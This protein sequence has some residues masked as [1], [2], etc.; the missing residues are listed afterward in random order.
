MQSTGAGLT[1]PTGPTG[2]TGVQ[3]TQGVTGAQGIQGLVGPTGPTG[4]KGATGPQGVAGPVDWQIACDYATTGALP[5]NTYNNGSSGVGATLTGIGLGALSVDGGSLSINQRI[6]VKNEATQANNGIYVVTVVGTVG[7]AYVLTRSTD[8]NQSSEMNVGDAV[9]ILNGVVNDD[10]TWVMVTEGTITVGTTAIVWVQASGIGPQGP[11]GAQGVQGIQGPI[12]PTG[13]TGATPSLPNFTDSRTFALMGTVTSASIPV[14]FEPVDSGVTKKLTNTRW[15][16]A[17][18]TA[19]VAVHQNG[20]NVSGLGAVLLS[21]ALGAT[22]PT[23][24]P[25]VTDGDRFGIVVSGVPV[26]GTATNLSM[27]LIFETTQ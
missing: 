14:F 27:S 17:S 11:T 26:T 22:A 13:A 7:T 6:L 9:F 12:G 5:T 8:Y 25:S 2:S 4:S 24:A 15:T 23:V 3:G 1:G 20:S 19:T 18:G 10:S 21:P 16:M